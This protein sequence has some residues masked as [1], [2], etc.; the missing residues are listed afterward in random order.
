MLKAK[1]M[2]AAVAQTTARESSVSVTLSRFTYTLT[3]DLSWMADISR[4]VKA[5][6]GVRLLPHCMDLKP[7]GILGFRVRCPK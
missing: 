3:S 6:P 5:P 2:S 4:F 7:D 1:I